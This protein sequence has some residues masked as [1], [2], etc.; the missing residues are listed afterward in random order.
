MNEKYSV[1]FEMN[2]HAKVAAIRAL[3]AEASEMREIAENT[4]DEQAHYEFLDSSRQ[5]QRLAS[6]LHNA[7][8]EV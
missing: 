7:E 2:Y 6:A 8:P 1:T 3:R 5:L 4:S